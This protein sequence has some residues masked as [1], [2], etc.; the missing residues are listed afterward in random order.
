MKG[1]VG[2]VVLIIGFG[3]FVELTSAVGGIV[4][5]AGLFLVMDWLWL[6]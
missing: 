5:G 4:M 1:L 2:L 3:V 6:G